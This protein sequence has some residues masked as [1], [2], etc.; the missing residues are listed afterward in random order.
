MLQIVVMNDQKVFRHTIYQEK[1]RFSTN[2][3]LC[4]EFLIVIITQC[5][6]L[7]FIVLAKAGQYCGQR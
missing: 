1:Y 7:K 2:Y 4:K 3:L 5:P 6:Y